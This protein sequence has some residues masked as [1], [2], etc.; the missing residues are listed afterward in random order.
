[1]HPKNGSRL[2][3][4]FRAKIP[5]QSVFARIWG[6]KRR[7][8]MNIEI[9]NEG[10]FLLD[11]DKRPRLQGVFIFLQ[12]PVLDWPCYQNSNSNS[13]FLWSIIFLTDMK[14]RTFL[15]SRP[16]FRPL[17]NGK[18][19]VHR[20][21]KLETRRRRRR[22]RI[23]NDIKQTSDRLSKRFLLKDSDR[24]LEVIP[25]QYKFWILQERVLP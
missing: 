16:Y 9:F 10:Y 15:Y 2:D 6:F 13:P 21:S 18:L 7:R 20:N 5:L 3:S 4:Y 22:R 24:N 11:L 8:K 1:M 23:M 25:I 17:R 19:G 14:I 12:V